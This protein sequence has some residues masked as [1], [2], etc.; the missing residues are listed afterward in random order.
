L[1]HF[2]VSSENKTLFDIIVV[3]HTMKNK[4]DYPKRLGIQH[5]KTQI[6]EPNDQYRSRRTKNRLSQA[7]SS[8]ALK[9]LLIG[10]DK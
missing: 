5:N 6:L 7:I 10:C 2:G 8:V 3:A 4:I 9:M 1:K